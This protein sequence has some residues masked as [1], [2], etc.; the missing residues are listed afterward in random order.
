MGNLGGLVAKGGSVE[1]A[2]KGRKACG[3]LVGGKKPGRWNQEVRSREISAGLQILHIVPQI[4]SWY[5]LYGEE[6]SHLDVGTTVGTDIWR[7]KGKKKGASQLC[8]APIDFW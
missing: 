2:A 5:G 7:A 3:A 4:A 6:T 1:D 8:E